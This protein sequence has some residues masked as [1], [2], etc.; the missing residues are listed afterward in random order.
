[1]SSFMNCTAY[2][3]LWGDEIKK[4]EDVG[5]SSSVG[6]AERHFQCFGGKLKERD[7][8]VVTGVDGRVMLRW[9]FENWDVR[10]WTGL[11]WLKIETVGGHL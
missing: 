2:T 4:N 9:M 3:R 11:R 5:A 7:H 10:V 6:G 8:L 1:M